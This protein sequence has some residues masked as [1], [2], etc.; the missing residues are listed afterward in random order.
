VSETTRWDDDSRGAMDA[1]LN[2]AGVLGLPLGAEA[3]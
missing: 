2:E 1:A 3:R